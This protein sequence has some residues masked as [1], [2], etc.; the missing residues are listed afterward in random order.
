MATPLAMVFRK[1]KTFIEERGS[2]LP[3]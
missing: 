1:V 3:P 2:C